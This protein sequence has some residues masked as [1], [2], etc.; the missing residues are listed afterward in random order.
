M[1]VPILTH[2][3]TETNTGLRAYHDD[4]AGP[5]N[6]AASTMSRDFRKVNQGL[7][8]LPEAE[9]LESL[10]S[11]PPRL[12]SPAPISKKDMPKPTIYIYQ[13]LL[14]KKLVYIM[15]DF[16]SRIDPDLTRTFFFL[17]FT[18]LFQAQSRW[19]APTVTMWG[20]ARDPSNGISPSSL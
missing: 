19:R 4:S 18:L 17:N 3:A 6:F 14:G 20:L 15:R 2:H 7:P 8:A 9:M 16:E 10:T 5:S 12:C 13:A 11:T 1:L